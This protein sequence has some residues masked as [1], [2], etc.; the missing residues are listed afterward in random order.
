MVDDSGRKAGFDSRVQRD[1]FEEAE[2]EHFRWTTAGPGFHLTEVDLLAPICAGLEGP[3]LEIGC[4][5]GNNL[6]RLTRHG[7]C[8]GVDLFP[9]KLSFARR[10]IPGVRFTTASADRLPFADASFRTILI[11]DLLHHVEDPG[12]V[13]QEAMRVL[14]PGGRFWL[15]EPNARSPIVRLQISLVPAEA[16]ARKFNAEY[17]SGLLSKLPLEDTRISAEQPFPLRRVMFHY[18]LGLPGLGKSR[19]ATGL[20]AG[21]EKLIGSLIPSSYHCYVVATARRS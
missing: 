9:R 6:A 8:Y 16:G 7:D 12:A 21:V 11:R 14:A 19:F 18:E 20:I 13:L 5:E 10:E 17:V 2:V 15:L 3:C 4:G 1:Y